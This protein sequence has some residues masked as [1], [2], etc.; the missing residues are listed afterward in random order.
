M[1]DQATYK[2]TLFASIGQSNLIGV[3]CGYW[4][5]A[6]APESS[7]LQGAMVFT[8]WMQISLLVDQFCMRIN[9]RDV[10]SAEAG[11]G[12][13]RRSGHLYI[14]TGLSPKRAIRP[15]EFSLDPDY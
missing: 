15:R 7:P 5:A 3:A 11:E 10:Q 6:G 8:F 13:H 4:I 1:K 9:T 14:R 2:A 12:V